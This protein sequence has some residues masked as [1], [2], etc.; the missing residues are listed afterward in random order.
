MSCKI[1]LVKVHNYDND[2]FKYGVYA[3]EESK[4]NGMME[5]GCISNV[6]QLFMSDLI[7]EAEEEYCVCE[8]TDNPLFRTPTFLL[9]YLQRKHYLESNINDIYVS[10]FA[11]YY[12]LKTC[13]KKIEEKLHC[14]DMYDISFG[15]EDDDIDTSNVPF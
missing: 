14:D 6:T 11:A 15:S 5:H 3:I 12:I 1:Y 8:G 9:N 13:L 10:P 4:I 2:S 7:E